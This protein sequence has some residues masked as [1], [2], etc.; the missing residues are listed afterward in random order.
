M[1]CHYED[2]DTDKKNVPFWKKGIARIKD[3]ADLKWYVPSELFLLVS[4]ADNGNGA[5]VTF[6]LWVKMAEWR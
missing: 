3:C 2:V 5:F 1:V 4:T 6:I